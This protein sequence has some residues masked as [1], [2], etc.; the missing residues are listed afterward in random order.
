MFEAYE[1]LAI[2]ILCVILITPIASGQGTII[3]TPLAF[4][5]VSGMMVK[6]IMLSFETTAELDD[7]ANGVAL[8]KWINDCV[9]EHA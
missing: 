1:E 8:P 2:A 6:I 7:I 5:T 4:I 9:D 3:C